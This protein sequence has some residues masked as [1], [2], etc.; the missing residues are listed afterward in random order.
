[1]TFEHN[2]ILTN[3]VINSTAVFT[4]GLAVCTE[5][6]DITINEQPYKML[7][8]ISKETRTVQSEE[9]VQTAAE[10]PGADPPDN[11]SHTV[12]F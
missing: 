6:C 4:P 2:N 7:W 12:P 10:L 8:E 11:N 5:H 1:M 9:K 3:G